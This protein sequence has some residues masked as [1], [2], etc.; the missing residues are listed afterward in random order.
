MEGLIYSRSNTLIKFIII[1]YHVFCRINRLLIFLSN[2]QAAE[3]GML[4]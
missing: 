4:Q 2:L 3:T 1:Y